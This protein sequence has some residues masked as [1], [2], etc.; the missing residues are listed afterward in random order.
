VTRTQR[1][2]HTWTVASTADFFGAE[3]LNA[4]WIA[5]R[6]VYEDA[7]GSSGTCGEYYSTEEGHGHGLD[8]TE[9]LATP[10]GDGSFMLTPYKF[11]SGSFD[12]ETTYSSYPCDAPASVVTDTETFYEQLGLLSGVQELVV[13]TPDPED[14]T[15][16]QG[17]ATIVHEETDLPGGKEINDISV[18]WSLV[19]RP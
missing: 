16:F 1:E 9:F 15:R 7:R 19:R 4:G 8:A 11:E 12:V 17:S 3:Q 2:E 14:P 6:E 13:L 10:N 5:Q 18:D